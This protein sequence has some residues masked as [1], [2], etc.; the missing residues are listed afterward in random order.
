VAPPRELP[1]LRIRVAFTADPE[2]HVAEL[3]QVL[4]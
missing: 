4:A 1:E 2:G 3:V